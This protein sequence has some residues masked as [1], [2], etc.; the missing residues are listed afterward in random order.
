MADEPDLA[1]IRAL[2]PK[3]QVAL[4][5]PILPVITRPERKPQLFDTMTRWREIAAECGLALWQVAIQYE[6]DASG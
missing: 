3:E 5:E 4:L 1:V 2:L 6:S